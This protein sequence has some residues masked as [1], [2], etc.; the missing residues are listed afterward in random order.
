MPTLS[1]QQESNK[2]PGRGRR[3]EPPLFAGVEADDCFVAYDFRA[4]HRAGGNRQSVTWPQQKFL[5]L[6]SGTSS[7]VTPP[8]AR[9]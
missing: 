5:A 7:K 1:C 2:R 3:R 4:M 6:M 8:A 9:S